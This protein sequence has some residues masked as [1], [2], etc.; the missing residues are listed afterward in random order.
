VIVIQNFPHYYMKKIILVLVCLIPF[1]GSAQDKFEISGKLSAVTS[2]RIVLLSYKNSNG[3][4]VRDSTKIRDNKFFLTG[5]TAF[6][7]KAEIS[8]LP[9]NKDSIQHGLYSDAQIFYLEK[10]KYIVIGSNSI[11]KATITGT[12]SQ[13]EYLQYKN[14]VEKTRA[15]QMALFANL[16]KANDAKD[17][18]EISKTQIELKKVH[19]RENAVQD[20]FIFSHPD[21]YVTLDI[22]D[23]EK[24]GYMEPIFFDPYYKSLSK[25]MLGSSTGKNM[26]E[27]YEK[28]Q[29]LNIGKT[30]DFNQ[31]DDKG[32]EF[33][34]SSLRGK[35]VLVDFWASWCGPC[36]GETPYLIKAYAELKDKKFEIVSISLDENKLAWLKAVASD[37]MTWIQVSDLKGFKNNVAIKYGITTIPRNVLI[38]PNGLIVAK[39]LRGEDVTAKLSALIK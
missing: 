30:L 4:T 6:G 1:A 36:R 21:S 20:S 13:N 7:N 17:T 22:I 12:N 38:D 31:T 28:A 29:K 10:G 23:Q 27:R 32:K 35:Y 11:S 33:D 8:L 3:K 2:G 34:L 26:T 19:A 39:D 24:A 18:T 37:K 14:Q 5:F 25:R 15:A 9:V 16:T